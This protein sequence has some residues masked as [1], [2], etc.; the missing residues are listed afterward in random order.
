MFDEISSSSLSTKFEIPQV[1]IISPTSF[2]IYINNPMKL[3]S[4]RV[5]WYA[6][7]STN[8]RSQ[9]SQ[10][11]RVYYIYIY[12]FFERKWDSPGIHFAI[13]HHCVTLGTD[14]SRNFLCSKFCFK[15]IKFSI[16]KSRSYFTPTQFLTGYKTNF[17]SILNTACTCEARSPSIFF[18]SRIRVNKSNAISHRDSKKFF[19][20]RL[21]ESAY[22][23]DLRN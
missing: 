9:S 21:V 23:K 13:N 16:F 4:D 19:F 14:Q 20:N 15:E 22:L 3:H 2:L 5:Y 11:N 10:N 8:N 12:W 6:D 18:S 1:S 7:D 17:V